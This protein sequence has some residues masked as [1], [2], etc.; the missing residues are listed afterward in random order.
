MSFIRRELQLPAKARGM[1]LITSDI[2]QALPEMSGIQV[3]LLHLFLRHTSAALAIN[4]NADPG[5]RRDLAMSLDHIVPESLPYRHTEEGPDDMP[6]H[7][8]SAL[9]GVELTVP[10][11]KGAMALG[12]WQGLYL[13]EFRARGGRRTIVMT[14]LGNS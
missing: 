8:K 10:V 13:C 11:E 1:H 12:T 7:V 9:L 2:T 3:G 6:A 5:V 14:L 4:E